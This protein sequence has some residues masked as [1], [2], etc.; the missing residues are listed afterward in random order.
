MSHF[1]NLS[2][3]NMEPSPS[4]DANSRSATQEVPNIVWNPKIQYRVNNNPSLVTILSQM[5]P[6]YIPRPNLFLKV[7][8]F[9]RGLA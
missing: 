3:D 4:W 7:P 2:V 6:A 5:N 1:E 9:V 8:F